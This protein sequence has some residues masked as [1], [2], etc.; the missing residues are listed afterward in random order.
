M[1]KQNRA[2]E[3]VLGTLHEAVAQALLDKVNSG[4]ATAQELQAAIK[5]LK[6]NGIEAIREEN[7]PLNK[8]SRIVLP[9]FDDGIETEEAF[10]N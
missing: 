6:D 1:A 4:E 5:F 2:T 3:K 9:E 8:L 10:P 7:D